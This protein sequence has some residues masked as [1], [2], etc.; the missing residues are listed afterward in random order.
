[1]G[2]G[3]NRQAISLCGGLDFF[4]EE[5]MFASDWCEFLD[6]CAAGRGK[7]KAAGGAAGAAAGSAKS[8]LNFLGGRGGGAG[9]GGRGRGR[10]GRGGK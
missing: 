6:V 2:G 1:M 10:G 5:S 7:K 8:M 4:A 3:F 9:G